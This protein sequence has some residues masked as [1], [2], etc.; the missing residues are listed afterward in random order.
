[1]WLVVDRC[2]SLTSVSQVLVY[3]DSPTFKSRRGIFVREVHAL[4]SGKQ[5][6]HLQNIPFAHHRVRSLGWQFHEIQVTRDAPMPSQ[7]SGLHKGSC[8]MESVSA[9]VLFSVS[10]IHT[11][12]NLALCTSNIAE[13]PIADTPSHTR[14]RRHSFFD[15]V[16][17][18]IHDR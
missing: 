6:N 18:L 8:S 12:H 16:P 17:I 7:M 10:G 13:F 15:N 5:P 9:A 2:G 4:W 11:H 14:S 1:M 3:A